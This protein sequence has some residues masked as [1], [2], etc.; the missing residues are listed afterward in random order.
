MVSDYRDT[1]TLRHLYWD[2][3]MSQIDIG[4]KFGVDS[5]TISREMSKR[6]I[7]T[8]SLSQAA[9]NKIDGVHF[10]HAD[11][12]YELWETR[13]EHEKQYVYV[14][15]LLAVAEYGFDAVCDNVVHHGSE[16]HLPPCE[17]PWAN[18]PG[19][20][21]VETLV[22][23]SRRHTG[24]TGA[25]WHDERLLR[26]MYETNTISE[27]ADELGCSYAT[28]H[29]AMEDNNIQRRGVGEKPPASSD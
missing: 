10:R 5:G 4:D 24:S 13:Y 19:N 16:S 3:G 2:K 9:S 11:K 22:E 20:L 25:P 21:E 14:H 29:K 8:R 26:E 17:I 28:I 15:R 27:I 18:W 7:P 12:G 23:H 6:N 1:E